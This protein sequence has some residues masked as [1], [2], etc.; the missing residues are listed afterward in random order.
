MT[1]KLATLAAVLMLVVGFGTSSLADADDNKLTI[2][3]AKFICGDSNVSPQGAFTSLAPGDYRTAINIHNP[4][5]RIVAI[6]KEVVLTES[7]GT[8]VPLVSGQVAQSPLGLEGAHTL[9]P[10]AAVEADCVS[11]L[12]IYH[13]DVTATLFNSFAKGFLIIKADADGTDK[14]AGLNVVAVYTTRGKG[15]TDTTLPITQVVQEVKGR[16][17][18]DETGEI[19]NTHHEVGNSLLG[20]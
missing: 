9:D 19:A 16:V 20:R 12:R 15:V 17:I 3:S 14:A 2:Y 10:F 8:G 1:K 5:N 18:E 11:L 7:G 13:T 4:N 6:T